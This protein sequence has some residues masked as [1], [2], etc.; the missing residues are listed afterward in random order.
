MMHVEYES[1]SKNL[2]GVR[3]PTKLVL[4]EK[5]KLNYAIF[6]PKGILTSKYHRWRTL[7]V[8]VW[9]SKLMFSIPGAVFLHVIETE[10]K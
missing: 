2:T 7:P 10:I 6:S 5:Q 8:Y 4:P 1:D 3:T 9:D